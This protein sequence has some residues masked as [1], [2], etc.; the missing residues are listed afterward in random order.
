MALG[1]LFWLQRAACNPQLLNSVFERLCAAGNLDRA[2]KLCRAAG[3]VAYGAALLKVFT[4]LN[5]L[6]QS[7]ELPAGL[8]GRLQELFEHE[9][10]A[11]REALQRGNLA[12]YASGA[13][14]GG[15]FVMAAQHS[16]P[17][18][19]W[20][21]LGVAAMLFVASLLRA[22]Y[23]IQS[24]LDAFPKLLPRLR[25]AAA[26]PPASAPAPPPQ[27]TGPAQADELV[28]SIYQGAALLRTER[29]SKPIIKIGKLASSDLYFDDSAV[30]RMHAI[31]ER[32]ADGQW[33]LLDLGSTTGTLCNG[34]KVNRRTLRLG[35]E[36][37]IGPARIV[38]GIKES[39]APRPANTASP[40]ELAA[41]SLQSPAPAK[42]ETSE[43]GQSSVRD[44]PC[45]GCGQR[46]FLRVPAVHP[47]AW[48]PGDNRP[49]ALEDCEARVCQGCGRVEW[50][51]SN[52]P[53]GD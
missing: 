46:R 51:L 14:V 39:A 7:G 23:I 19:L 10:A 50:F 17:L 6:Q 25:E 36:I 34:E 31:I 33:H 52:V 11:Q 32:S 5:E 45:P 47:G 27:E 40:S 22:P 8:E 43:P 49:L 24:S 20:L 16:E 13:L 18:H 21:A 53:A 15:G 48:R 37:G 28:L 12:T 44:V 29:F 1:H 4:L 35:D 9:M 41:G 26:K 30:S 42:T 38:V 3:P 2:V